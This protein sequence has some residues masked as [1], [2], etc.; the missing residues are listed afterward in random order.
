MTEE[1]PS[2]S[3]PL[4]PESHPSGLQRFGEGEAVTSIA[5]EPE[6][7]AAWIALDTVPD[8]LQPS[9][10]ASARLAR[11]EASGQVSDEL[12]LPENAKPLGPTGAAADL[13]CPGEHD[14]W[15]VTSQ[16]WLFHLSVAGESAGGPPDAAFAE[17]PGELPITFRPLDESI[18][19]T[20]LDTVPEEQTRKNETANT[21][22][23]TTV[24]PEPF[25]RVPVQLVSHVHSRLVHGTTLEL[26]FHLAVKARVQLIAERRRRIIA[27]TADETLRAGNRKLL[28]RLNPK[29]WPTK[30]KL[31][32]RNL[33]PLPTV[34]TRES[35]SETNAVS[36]AERLPAPLGWTGWNALG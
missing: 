30:L 17:E 34:S 21:T 32:T 35:G 29:R 26:S 23:P 8:E 16:G 19:Q 7:H 9:A 5:A 27:K 20:V 22:A 33:A 18:P 14:C 36:T 15:L 12:V 3:T 11:V 10:T 1:S 24:A 31:N 6:T 2:W 4:G 25:L 28:L 13:A